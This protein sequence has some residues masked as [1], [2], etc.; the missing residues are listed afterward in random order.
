M[1]SFVLFSLLSVSTFSTDY[2][3]KDWV[4]DYEN[5]EIAICPESI[6]ISEDLEVSYDGQPS[7][8]FFENDT[9]IRLNHTEVVSDG[10]DLATIELVENH[11]IQLGSLDVMKLI[12][13]KSIEKFP[14]FFPEEELVYEFSD[15]FSMAVEN[16]LYVPN[17]LSEDDLQ[18]LQSLIEDQFEIA[19][20]DT[21]VHEFDIGRCYYTEEE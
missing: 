4:L 15:I 8:R 17:E 9:Q 6:S 21:Y 20:K 19:F 1:K 10:E 11:I 3:A 7:V 12:V 2:L 14:S 13:Y 18:Y 5:S 16:G